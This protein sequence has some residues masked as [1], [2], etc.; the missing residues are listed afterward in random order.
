MTEELRDVIGRLTCRYCNGNGVLHTVV[1]QMVPG[2]TRS[3]HTHRPCQVCG[4]LGLALGDK[5]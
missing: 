2:E 4:G 5:E 3:V 1:T